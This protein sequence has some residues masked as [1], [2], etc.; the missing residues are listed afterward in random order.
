MS[1]WNKDNNYKRF[2]SLNKQKAYH[3]FG[4]KTVVT[5]LF[6]ITNYNSTAPTPWYSI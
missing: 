1:N 3:G 4:A 6:Y 2:V 5:A